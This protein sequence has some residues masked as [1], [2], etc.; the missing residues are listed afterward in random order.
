M[1]WPFLASRGAGVVKNAIIKIGVDRS[2]VALHLG[3]G[4]VTVW[5]KSEFFQQWRD[6]D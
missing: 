5:G 4:T 1:T 3:L 2:T 6:L